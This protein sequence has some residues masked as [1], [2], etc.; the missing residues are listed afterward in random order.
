MPDRFFRYQPTA[1]M[2]TYRFGQVPAVASVGVRK[3][4]RVDTWDCYAGRVTGVDDLPSRV[5]EFPYLNPVSGPFH[6]T[7][8]HPGD[9]LAI[10][11]AALTP[12]QPFG[13]S[14]TFPHFG[15]LTSTTDT[16]TLQPPLPERVWRYDIDIDAGTVDYQARGS[17]YR[18]SMPLQPMLGT[19]GVAPAAG[20]S[21]MTIVPGAHGGNLDVPEIAA[22]ATVYLGVH[23][24]GALFAIGDGHARQGHGEISGAAVETAMTAD[25]IVDVIPGVPTPWPRIETDTAIHSVGCA[26]PLEDAVRIG[27][28]DLTGWVSQ[29]TGLDP[30]DA[31]QLAA[32]AGNITVGNVCDALYTAP[33]VIGKRFLLGE[34]PYGGAHQRLR[35]LADTLRSTP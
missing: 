30:L 26:R 29:L 15:T 16:A 3:L 34:Q 31:Y 7:G 1:D 25:L 12:R 6:V 5:C 17:D 33:A 9:T 22:G 2:L 14:S 24:D 8:A 32:Q 13:F 28:V 10:H 35:A 18:V 19:I 21:R 23:T 11:I 20:E 4:L 27:G